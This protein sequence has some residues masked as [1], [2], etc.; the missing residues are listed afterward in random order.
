M[1]YTKVERKNNKDQVIG[2]HEIKQTFSRQIPIP[3]NAKAEDA[4]IITEKDR[5]TI[6][7]PKS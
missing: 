1:D 6:T 7:L 3:D 2:T 5:V 4:E